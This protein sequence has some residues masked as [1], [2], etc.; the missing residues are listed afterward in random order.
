MTGTT[1]QGSI[2][3]ASTASL[4]TETITGT[5]SKIT[6]GSSASCPAGTATYTVTQSKGAV[7]GVQPG[8]FVTVEKSKVTAYNVTNTEVKSA[9]STTFTYC[10][11][12]TGEAEE[13]TSGPVAKGVASITVSGTT[14]TAHVTA[15]PTT[16]FAVGQKVNIAGV[17]STSAAEYNNKTVELL[18]VPTTTSFTFAVASGTANGI[19]GTIGLP[20]TGVSE[21]AGVA[22][23]NL[24]TEPAAPLSAGQEVEIANVAVT[25]YNG[26]FKVKEVLSP[27]SFTYEDAAAKEAVASGG[28]E[29]ASAT[30]PC[31]YTLPAGIVKGLNAG[32]CKI[33]AKQAGNESYGAATVTLELTISGGTQSLK[34]NPEGGNISSSTP[35]EV[36][37]TT[38]SALSPGKITSTTEAVCTVGA[39]SEAT[40]G[41]A[42]VTVTPVTTG[43]CTLS[44]SGNEGT[45]NWTLLKVTT[46]SFTVTSEGTAQT[47]TFAEPTP[48][49]LAQSPVTLAGTASSKLPVT[50]KS[51]TESVCT[52]GGAHGEALTLV[53]EGTCKITAE[54]PGEPGVYAP[55]KAVSREF[56]VAKAD[57][58]LVFSPL[59]NVTY[60]AADFAIKGTGKA[61]VSVNAY[62]PEITEGTEATGLQ[63]SYEASGAC[64]VDAEGTTVHITGAGTC[65][66][67]A[68]QPGTAQ[69]REAPEIGVKFEIA[70]A[71]SSITFANPGQQ[72]VGTTFAPGATSSSGAPVTYTAT[73]QCAITGSNEVETTTAGSCTV[74]AHSAATANYNQPTRVS[75]TFEVVEAAKVASFSIDKLQ[76][77]AGGGSFTTAKLTAEIG[78]TVEYEIVVKNTGNVTLTFQALTDANCSAI[79]PSGEE[80]VAGA[81]EQVYTCSHELTETG[82]YGNEASIEGN[83]GTGT[84]TS[85]NVEVEV[86]AAPR[87]T[88]EKSQRLEGEL[89]YTTSKLA[90]EDGET[91]E[92][93][94]VVKNTGNTT[95]K[96]QPLVDA[97][98]SGISPSGGVTI[99]R[100]HEQVYA[101]S[102]ELTTTGVHS[103]EASIEAEGAGTKTSNKVELSV[104]TSAMFTIEKF[105]EVAG[106]KDGFTASKL[107]SEVGQTIDY[108]VVVTNTG[109]IPLKFQPLTDAG[110]ASI[111]PSGEVTVGAGEEQT[112]TCS[113]EL[114]TGGV[115]S[116]EA[117]I[118]ANEGAGT[119]ASNKVEVQAEKANQTIDFKVGEHTFGEEEFEISAT[120]TSGEPVVFSVKSGKCEIVGGDKVHLTGTGPCTILASQAGNA[121]YN[122]AEV[123]ETFSINAA[124]QTITF[125]AIPN[126]TSESPPVEL[127]ATA[128]S[129]LPVSYTATGPCEISGSKVIITGVGTCAVTASQKG[130]ENYNAASSVTREFE[131]SG[132]K[133]T[134][135]L[136]FKK[137]I[138]TGHTLKVT[139]KVKAAK[140]KDKPQ[141]T[142]SFYF[143]G[144]LKAT[145]NL[146]TKGAAK[147]SFVVTAASGSYPVQAVFS[148]AT[149]QNQGSSSSVGTVKVK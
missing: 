65:T 35:T 13:K 102:Y 64:T 53:G 110:C 144:V 118:E 124:E 10:V 33:E 55:A 6:D 113:H 17:K 125:P 77:I 74:T 130:N 138:S 8:D 43:T 111:A 20:N 140:A 83:E 116:N 26:S 133:T 48:K 112:Y 75:Q 126:Q 70:R 148:S 104:A 71:S 79:T 56:R 25:T 105:Q 30:A 3:A 69:Y 96:F 34:W 38:N 88:I 16:A 78:Q 143:N 119:E 4:L 84:K 86:A 18:S 122:A 89:G 45:P 81:G 5:F 41:T 61:A 9:T 87:F 67:T 128:S 32:K 24:A 132:V 95:L 58:L 94:I 76:K 97:G 127:S 12:K 120:A 59:P 90:G 142:V 54:Q 117:S 99:K 50:Y 60:G 2:A 27:K 22:T 36:S 28:G 103:N 135:T 92:Y 73:G 37:A 109:N 11:A 7:D 139:A 136:R 42:V 68:K 146:S 107:T 82:V 14:A 52:T 131:I 44:A 106:S 47:V 19:N 114:T 80:T 93:Q 39:T 98:C 29:L 51:T 15:A 1:S 63:P 129:G 72:K 57:Q 147:A 46:K 121:G 108:I 123:E 91:V 137:M 141:G 23:V 49:T 134:T 149:L 21:T 40:K 31:T 62:S 101:C 115:Y 85:N 145:V 100:N 66:I